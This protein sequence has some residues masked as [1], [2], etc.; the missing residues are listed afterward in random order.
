MTRLS[1]VDTLLFDHLFDPHGDFNVLQNRMMQ[2]TNL[3]LT[4]V[5][6]FL[7]STVEAAP[8]QGTVKVFILTGQSK[9]ERKG[10]ALNQETYKQDLLINE[11]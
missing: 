11:A 3:V 7:A 5:I 10:L 1:E 9:K 6:L 8:P 4:C 2:M